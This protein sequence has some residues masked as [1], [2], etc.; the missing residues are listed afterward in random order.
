MS[1]SKKFCNMVRPP[2]SLPRS[3][4]GPRR[5]ER[6]VPAPWK[7]SPLL[8]ENGDPRRAAPA[9]TWRSRAARKAGRPGNPRQTV[10]RRH[11]EPF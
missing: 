1:T 5:A 6:L 2:V 8:R 4:G 7:A 3:P 10:P 11:P 9:S